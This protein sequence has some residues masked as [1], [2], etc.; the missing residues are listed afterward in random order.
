LEPQ[1]DF[2][3]RRWDEAAGHPLGAGQADFVLLYT[4]EGMGRLEW[5]ANRRE[6]F[7]TWFGPQEVNINYYPTWEG[8]ERILLLTVESARSLKLQVLNIPSG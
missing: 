2:R 1:D 3:D 7:T 8:D 4:D 5:P 6:Q